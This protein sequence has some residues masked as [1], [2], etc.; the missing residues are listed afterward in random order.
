MKLVAGMAVGLFYFVIA[1]GSYRRA[2]EGWAE[3]HG[4]LG[5]WW[6]VI[7]SFLAIAA[8]VAVVGTWRHVRGGASGNPPRF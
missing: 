3:G 8:L 7:G 5:F 2:A 4:D 1:F 6:A